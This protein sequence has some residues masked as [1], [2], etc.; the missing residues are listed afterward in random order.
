MAFLDVKNT[1][2]LEQ[3]EVRK[4]VF[5]IL[6]MFLF[7][8]TT[9]IWFIAGPLVQLISPDAKTASYI[10]LFG[11]LITIISEIISIRITVK[12]GNIDAERSGANHGFT[13][14]FLS[15]FMI[16]Y[17]FLYKL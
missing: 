14:M 16:L 6:A 13:A 4:N 1:P 7:L 3:K 5:G 10:A 15:I 12:N 9:L 11:Y 8:A 17:I 2:D